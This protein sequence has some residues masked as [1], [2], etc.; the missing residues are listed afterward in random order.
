MRKIRIS[1]VGFAIVAL[2]ALVAGQS[3]VSQ[4]ADAKRFVGT[5]RLVETRT[6]G[7]PDPVR[8]LHPTGLIYYDT[9]GHMAAQIMPEGG[10]RAF[11]GTLPTPEE[12]QA[13]LRG[14]TAYW[15]TYTVDERARTVTHHREGNINP[16][17]FGDFVRR[18]EFLPGDRVALRPMENQNQLIWERIR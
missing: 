8:G 5:W 11:A 17:A 3:R 13:A 16:G 14:Y 15:G 6:D 4:G 1:L 18:Y 10:R 9:T 12:A 2:A 7:A